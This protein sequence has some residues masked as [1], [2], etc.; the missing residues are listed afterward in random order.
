VAAFWRLEKKA[1]LVV[2]PLRKLKAGERKAVEEEAR[3][4][5]AFAEPKAKNAKVEFE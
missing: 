5:L 2:E 4:L 3:G 1:T